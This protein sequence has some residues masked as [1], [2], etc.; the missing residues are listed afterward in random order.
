[1]DLQDPA[2]CAAL[3]PI[4]S[5]AAALRLERGQGLAPADLLAAQRALHA[6]S[7]A[8]KRALARRMEDMPRV[9]VRRMSRRVVRP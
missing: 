3:A 6:L 1:M 2:T 9:S 5:P 8:D 4:L 7:P